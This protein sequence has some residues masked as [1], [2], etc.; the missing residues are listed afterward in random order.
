MIDAL[1][2]H[3]GDPQLVTRILKVALE[4]IS[5]SHMGLNANHAWCFQKYPPLFFASMFLNLPVRL[6]LQL[7]DQPHCAILSKFCFHSRSSYTN[8]FR[9]SDLLSQKASTLTWP[10][11]TLL[12]PGPNLSS[13]HKLGCTRCSVCLISLNNLSA[14]DAFLFGMD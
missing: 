2:F 3:S 8:I 4:P 5:E 13:Q 6:L 9:T 12:P 11:R 7:N 14:P 10:L 1:N